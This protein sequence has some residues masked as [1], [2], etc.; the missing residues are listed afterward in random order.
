MMAMWCKLLAILFEAI[1]EYISN[2]SGYYYHYI[3]V[4]KYLELFDNEIKREAGI[5]VLSG[6]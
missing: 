6:P 2:S 5:G 4:L 3:Y 1:F